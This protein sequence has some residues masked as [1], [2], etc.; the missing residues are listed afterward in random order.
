M[1]VLEKPEFYQAVAQVY[2]HWH[3]VSDKEVLDIMNKW[4]IH[5]T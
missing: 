5:H 1:V 4:E 2:E 3:D